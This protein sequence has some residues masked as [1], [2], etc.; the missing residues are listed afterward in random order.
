MMTMIMQLVSRMRLRNHQFQLIFSN[1][2]W[3][4]FQTFIMRS[5]LPVFSLIFF[6]C[7]LYCL[8]YFCNCSIYA[9][10]L[11]NWTSQWQSFNSDHTQDP[12]YHLYA[13]YITSKL[14][15]IAYLKPIINIIYQISK[16]IFTGYFLITFGFIL[17]RFIICLS[18]KNTEFVHMN[19]AFFFST[20]W[21]PNQNKTV[22]CRQQSK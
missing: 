12:V 21:K 19:H 13:F 18:I 2:H 7:V 9:F 17:S 22:Y 3:L 20:K 4:F 16:W 15:F 5:V 10:L 1:V 11:L 8:A 14:F 6:F